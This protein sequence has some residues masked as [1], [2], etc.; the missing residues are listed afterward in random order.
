MTLCPV[1]TMTQEHLGIST[2]GYDYFD[3]NF[4]RRPRFLHPDP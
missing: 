2:S 1:T 3:K 4:N